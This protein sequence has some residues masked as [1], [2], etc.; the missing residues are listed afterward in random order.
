MIRA[1]VLPDTRQGFTINLGPNAQA[2]QLE[3]PEGDVTY[4]LRGGVNV[5]AD[6]PRKPDVPLPPGYPGPYSTVD[7]T[8]DSI[9]LWTRKKG[10]RRAGPDAP[11]RQE[12]DEPLQLYA[13]GNV[14][15][16][17]DERKVAGRGDEKVFEFE[18]VYFDLRTDRMFGENGRIFTNTPGLLAPLRTDGKVINQYRDVTGYNTQGKPTLGPKFIRVD[19]TTSTGSRF[20][21]PGYQFAS[22]SVEI[23]DI[24]VP[25]TDQATGGK[26]GRGRTPDEQDTI[27]QFRA[28]NNVYYL[29]D[30]ARLLLA[31]HQVRERLRPASCAASGSSRATIFGQ[32]APDST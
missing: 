15:I 29:G 31:L 20:P 3:T 13:E 12:E 25:L 6:M 11:V 4:I 8:A 19:D 17:Q 22:S 26:V 9:V 30:G 1:P 32:Q 18:H 14:R 16:R 28:F 7:V 5:I 21:V 10:A 27:Y 24:T 23:E 2:E